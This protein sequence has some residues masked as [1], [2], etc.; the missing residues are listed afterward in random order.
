MN[1]LQLVQAITGELGITQPNAVATS[2]DPQIIQ[3]YALL[4]KVGTDLISEFEW[5]RLD[6]EYR[7]NTVVITTTGDTVADSAVITNIPT[8]AGIVAG[9]FMATGDGVP[10][11]CYVTSIDSLTQ[12]T[13]NQAVTDTATAADLVFTQTKYTLPSD[14]DRQVNRTQWDKTNHWELIGP[15]SAQEWQYLKGGIVSTGPRMRYRILGNTFQIWPPAISTARLGFEYISNA[16]VYAVDGV[17]E[18]S[19]FTVDTDTA[20]FR[21]RLLIT[22]TKYEFFQIK[23]FDVT[24]LSADY[25]AEIEKE[26]AS[27]HGAPTLSLSPS[28]SPMLIGPYS[29]PDSNFGH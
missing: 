9:T 3:I 12:V 27:D 5:N 20:I 25:N 28:Q 8:T 13:L 22:G 17:T 16:W 15:K 24:K 1:L 21:D 26:K 19:H 10:S 29:V 23:G 4:N 11:D 7:F 14:W 2:N 6:K 18:K